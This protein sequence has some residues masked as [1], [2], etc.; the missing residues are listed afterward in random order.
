MSSKISFDKTGNKYFRNEQGELHRDDGPAVEYSYGSKWWYQNGKLHRVDGPAVE[1]SNGSLLWY[2]NDKLHRED[3]PAI[4]QLD[5]TK[6]WFEHGV[7]IREQRSNGHT[8][9]YN[10]DGRVLNEL[11]L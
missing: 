1:S 2:Q 9:W 5:N 11:S 3:G 10:K 6:T 4:E 7:K 8:I